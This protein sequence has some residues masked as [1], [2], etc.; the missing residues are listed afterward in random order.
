MQNAAFAPLD[1]L[2]HEISCNQHDE[3]NNDYVQLLAVLVDKL[4]PLAQ[5]HAHQQKEGVPG[6]CAYG[7]EE[8]EPFEV[9]PGQASRE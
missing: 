2:V 9:H 3:D 5:L 1:V 7:C 8:D 4:P 6:S